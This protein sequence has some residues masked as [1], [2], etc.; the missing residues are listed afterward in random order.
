MLYI[1]YE[2]TASSWGVLFFCA[3]KY[4]LTN[5]LYF[6]YACCHKKLH[7]QLKA[8]NTNDFKRSTRKVT[9]IEYKSI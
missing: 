2:M 5:N 7:K 1:G 4:N 8:P 9:T 3:V 6:I